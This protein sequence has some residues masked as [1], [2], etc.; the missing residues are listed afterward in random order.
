VWDDRSSGAPVWH[1]AY[2][3]LFYLDLYLSESEEAFRPAAFHRENSNFL[4][5]LPFPPYVVMTPAEV[6]HRA[7]LLEYLDQCREKCFRVLADL[8]EE[9]CRERSSFPWLDFSVGDLML[10]NMRHVQH[11]TGQLNFILQQLTGSAPGWVILGGGTPMNERPER[12]A[13]S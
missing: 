8:S 5:D 4:R 9:K 10:Y 11:H 7:Q 6:Y 1:L 3:T 13:E 12:A 2:H